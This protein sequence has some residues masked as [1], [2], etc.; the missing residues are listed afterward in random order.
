VVIQIIRGDEGA[1]SARTYKNDENN[2]VSSS[3]V[4]TVLGLSDLMAHTSQVVLSNTASGG[5][6]VLCG[7]GRSSVSTAIYGP[8]VD[9]S[10]GIVLNDNVVAHVRGPVSKRTAPPPNTTLNTTV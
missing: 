9:A 10:E 6:A 4:A 2:A 1:C 3:Q 5:A 7:V 8:V